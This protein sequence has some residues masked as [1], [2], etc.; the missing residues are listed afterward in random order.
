MTRAVWLGRN[1]GAAEWDDWKKM[2]KYNSAIP[3]WHTD[4]PWGDDQGRIFLTGARLIGTDG[5]SV[6]WNYYNEYNRHDGFYA[7]PFGPNRPPGVLNQE[8]VPI[9]HIK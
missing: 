2:E 7:T 8:I 3:S 6:L 1:P 5:Q 4:S 9:G